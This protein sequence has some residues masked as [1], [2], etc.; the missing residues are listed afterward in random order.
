MIKKL[1]LIHQMTFDL[2]TPEI[3]KITEMSPEPDPSI[4][5][6][7]EPTKFTKV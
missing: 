4:I 2:Q 6:T 7:P 1:R 5:Y 3:L